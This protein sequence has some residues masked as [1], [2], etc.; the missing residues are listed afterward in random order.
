MVQMVV[1]AMK[2]TC[3][4]LTYESKDAIEMKKPLYDMFDIKSLNNFDT[5]C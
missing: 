3:L 2:N 4:Y 1:T 5:D